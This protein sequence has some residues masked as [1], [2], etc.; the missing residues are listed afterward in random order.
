MATHLYASDA[1]CG[2]LDLDLST[3]TERH[4]LAIEPPPLTSALDARAEASKNGLAGVVIEI[5]R[6]C[7]L[8]EQLA[9]ARDLNARNVPV[10]FYWPGEDAVERM[11]AGRVESHSRVRKAVNVWRRWKGI[12]QFG[13]GSLGL[14]DCMGDRFVPRPVIAWPL[15]HPTPENPVDGQG[16]YLRLDYWNQFHSGGS[17]GHTVHVMRELARRG[18]GS[19]RAIVNQI[20]EIPGRENVH[21]VEIPR[22]GLSAAELGVIE[23]NGLLYERLRGDIER[24]KPAFI[25]ERLVLGSWLGARI[26]EELR[27]PYVVEYNGSETSIRRS[28]ATQQYVCEP[29][30]VRIEG[31]VFDQATLISVVSEHVKNDLLQRGVP[32]SRILV[33]PNGADPEIYRPGTPAERAKVRAELGL[34]EDSVVIGFSGTFGGWHGID[35]LADSLPRILA[36]NPRARFLL[37]GDGNFKHLVDASVNKHRLEERVIRTGSVAQ[38]DGAR[39]LRACDILVSPHNRNMVDSPFFGSPT[40]LFEYMAMGAGIVASDLEQIG[41][42]LRPALTPA[43]AAQGLPAGEAR[44]VLCRPG[45]LDE[46]VGAVSALAN[47]PDL[48]AALGKNA[49]A[50][51]I[52]DYS[53]SRHVDRLFEALAARR[54][55]ET[56][57]P[58]RAAAPARKIGALPV[59]QQADAFK[60]ETQKQWNTDACGSHYVQGEPT[61]LDWY[62]D[63]ERHRYQEYAPWMPEVMEFGRHQGHSVLE[64]GAG[65][66]TDLA[67]F[68]KNGA[69]VTD[70]DLSRGHLEHAQRNFAF[71]GLTGR[72][73]HQDAETLPFETGE[74]DV[75]YSNGVIHHTPNTANLVAEVS[76]VLKPGGRAIIMVYAENSWHYWVELVY[77]IGLRQRMLGYFSMGEIMSRTVERSDASGARPL[78]KVYTEQRLRG[79]FAG[80]EIET[81]LQRQLTPTRWMRRTGLAGWIEKKFGW[82]LIIKAR[83]AGGATA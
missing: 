29:E 51:L 83:K 37:I 33:N 66:G 40:K 39:Y 60:V 14:M 79:L 68:A 19:L 72:F 41:E 24:L 22:E 23:A 11:D 31:L 59:L 47:N 63:V 78:V 32:E 27:I 7:A 50:A 81:V 13:K 10:F 57:E 28:F 16:L 55:T 8:E 20:Y 65:M 75:V 1:G 9:L 54:Q 45:D 53:W 2:F 73:V 52:G 61:T 15:G 76:R 42:V 77:K 3:L 25:Y 67:Q 6:G 38:R 64:I 12:P 30:L 62:L 56:A 35:L 46:F 80:F 34:P 48:A 21:Q 26:S 71:R 82:N 49:R 43:A 69:R 70:V 36:D 5:P 44:A 74:F 58:A 4:R 17:Y 18:R